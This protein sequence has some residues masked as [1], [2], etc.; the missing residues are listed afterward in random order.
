MAVE[1]RVCC[2][3]CK[4]IVLE[5]RTLLRA[6]CG[7]MLTKRPTLDLCEGCRVLLEN[8]IG[9]FAIEASPTTAPTTPLC[10]AALT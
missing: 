4:N 9:S 2:D 1:I 7:P 6:E 8:W 3:R 5:G 10:T